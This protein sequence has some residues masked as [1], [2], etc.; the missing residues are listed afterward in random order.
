MHG[1]AAIGTGS[2]QI[3]SGIASNPIAAGGAPSLALAWFGVRFRPLALPVSAALNEAPVLGPVYATV[4]SGHSLPVYRSTSPGS[5]CRS[6]PS[7]WLGRGS[8]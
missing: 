5:P 7:Y 8:G 4:V 1:I 6:S 3:V 2:D